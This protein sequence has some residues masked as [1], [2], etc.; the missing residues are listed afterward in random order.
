MMAVGMASLLPPLVKTRQQCDGGSVIAV[1]VA[2][3][4]LAVVVIVIVSLWTAGAV[5]GN[6]DG[7]VATAVADNVFVGWWW[8]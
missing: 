5:N 7:I 1:I 3:A 8:Q 2:M 4:A 6:G